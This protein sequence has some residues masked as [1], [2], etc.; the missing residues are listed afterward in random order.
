MKDVYVLIDCNNFYASCEQ[1]FDPSLRGKPV[2][3][4]S[5][6]DGCVIARSDAA[7]AL[8]IPMGYPLFKCWDM[9]KREGIKVF[10]SNFALY[11]D[12]SQRVMQILSRYSPAMEVY[13]IDEAF[14]CLQGFA[15]KDMEA[16]GQS[17]RRDIRKATGLPVS[18]GM[19]P[20]KTLAKV[21]NHIVKKQCKDKGVVCLLGEQRIRAALENMPVSD[22]WGVGKRRARFLQKLGVTSAFQLRSLPD[23][24]VKKHLTVTGLRMVHELRGVPCVAWEQDAPKKKAILTSRSFGRKVRARSELKEAVCAYAARCAEKMRGQGSVAGQ[25]LVFIQSD[26]FNTQ[27][28]YD[29]VASTAMH[30]PTADTMRIAALAQALVE[31]IYRPGYDYK[32]AGVM[33]SSFCDERNAPM[34]LFGRPYVSSRRQRL[35]KTLDRMNRDLRG[36]KV[37]LASEGMGQPWY[38]RQTRKSARYTTRWNE[39]LEVGI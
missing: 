3:V 10:S 13:S 12:M 9:V 14:L 11:G 33:L 15:H 6:N 24:W 22:I 28:F 27:H 32:R 25:L 36:G 8:G 19:G 21:A 29:N 17:I 37:F 26:P 7:K 4:L 16:Y 23:R 39:L 2:V 31:R 35:M 5:N 1:V 34:D 30:P 18:I 38:M 20:T